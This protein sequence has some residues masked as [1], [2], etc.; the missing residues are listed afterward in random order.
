MSAATIP[1]LGF[2]FLEEFPPEQILEQQLLDSPAAALH[3]ILTLV[4]QMAALM[5][6]QTQTIARLNSDVAILKELAGPR[7]VEKYRRRAERAAAA[8]AVNEICGECWA[9]KCSCG[10]QAEGEVQ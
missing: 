4:A 10:Q 8:A 5:D 2:R 1:H 3:E 7:R 6:A 9:T